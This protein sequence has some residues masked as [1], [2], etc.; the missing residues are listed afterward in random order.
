MEAFTS[1]YSHDFV[2]IAS[3][4]PRTKVADVPANLAETIRLAKAGSTAG[5][6]I[7]IFPELG[8]S[9]YAIED[10]L[11]QDALLGAVEV[12]IDELINVS[13]DLYPVL[14][15]GAPLRYAGG[16]FNTAVVIAQGSVLGIVPK[17]YLPNYREFYEKRHFTSGDGHLRR[18]IGIAGRQAPFGVDLLFRSIGSVDLMFHVELCED[19]WAPLPPSTTAALAGAEVLI[20]LSASNIT[21]GKADTRRLLCASQSARTIAAYA[22]SAAGPGESTTDLAWDGHAAIYEHG[23][24]LAETERFARNSTFVTADVDL[25]ESAR[26]ACASTRS[27]IVPERNL[28]ERP[29][30]APYHFNST[31]RMIRCHYGG[32]SNASPL[33]RP[34]QIS[35]ANNATR[36]TI[37]RFRVWQPGCR[38]PR[39]SGPLSASP[40]DSI[41]R[42]RSSSR[43]TRWIGSSFLAATCSPT[44]CPALRRQM[45]PN[46]MPRLDPGP[47]CDRCGNR[48][49]AHGAADAGRSQA[50]LCEGRARL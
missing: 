24:L 5:A 44:P 37:S 33:C 49:P 6:A 48:Y 9:S 29:S 34:I 13:R 42:R 28:D 16:L 17:T 7:M 40:A 22:Y 31:R 38:R 19:F 25:G 21:I 46:A 32:R 26:S 20:N 11:F 23:E 35:C 10:L 3:C 43:P 18:K 45:I 27:V 15:V 14:I 36:P 41:Q 2:R 1:L 8:L 50:S 4:V 12:A 30:F 47:W 39:S